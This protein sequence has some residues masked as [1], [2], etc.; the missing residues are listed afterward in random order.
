MSDGKHGQQ[1]RKDTGISYSRAAA[2]VRNQ[3]KG[4]EKLSAER[5][6]L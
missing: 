4:A 5:R 3:G 1:K 2:I 6:P